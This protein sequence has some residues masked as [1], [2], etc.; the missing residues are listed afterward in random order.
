ME[1]WVYVRTY[2]YWARMFDFGNGQGAD[3][4]LFAVTNETTGIPAVAIYVGTTGGTNFPFPS[5]VP[6]NTWTHLAA[7][8]DGTSL[9]T[10]YV[11]G[12]SVQTANLDATRVELGVNRTLNFVGRSSWQS[13]AYADGLYDDLRIWSVCRTASQI[14][15]RLARRIHT[16]S[17]N[18]HASCRSYTRTLTG[19][20][21]GLTLYYKFE[22]GSGTVATNAASTGSGYDG[23]LVN[24]PTYSTATAS[25]CA[26]LD[27]FID[28][29]V[30]LCT[31]ACVQFQSRC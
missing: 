19:T 24:S 25:T 4:V 29:G 27:G 23:T 11:N 10:M 21:S 6:L 17:V 9:W 12:A 26:C 8:F 20:E 31:G 14:F 22:E 1:G 2:P 18:T 28:T 30:P 7:T 5:A 15:T 16:N 13:D 3:N